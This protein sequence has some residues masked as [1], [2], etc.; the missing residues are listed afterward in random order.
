MANNKARAA[1]LTSVEAIRTKLTK[2]R[3][4]SFFAGI[5]GFDLGFERAGIS[6]A[7]HCELNSFCTSVLRRHWPSVPCVPNILEVTAAEI[8]DA[9]VWCGG[10]PCQDVSVARGWLGRDGLKGKNTGLF[11]PFAELVKQKMPTVVLMENVSGLL[12]SHDGRDFA[13]ILQTFQ[14]LGY[15]VAWRIFNTRYFGAPQ[16][17]PRVY[18]CAWKNSARSALNV[19]YEP[20]CTTTPES[21]R[22]GFLRPTRCEETGAHVPEVAFCLAATSGR[23]TGTDWS[24]SYISYHD[25]VR[26][27]TP[28]ECEKLQGFPE[29]WTLPHEDFHLSDDAIDT[30]RYHAIGNAVSVP[31][32]EWVARRIATELKATKSKA[33]GLEPVKAAIEYAKKRVPDFAS[34]KAS[35]VQIET[36][37][38]HDDAPKIKWNNG[39]VMF[40][41]LCHMSP[42]SPAPKK[43]I[44]SR[45]VDSL[46]KVKPSSRYFLSP[47]AATGILR[48]VESQERQ[49]FDPLATALTRLAMK[50]SLKHSS[51]KREP[52]AQKS[53]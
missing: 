49:L 17:R 24:R 14:L 8:P 32:V 4:N 10:F 42:V 7:F 5:G 13:V 34:A 38:D 36:F 52:L 3:L 50:A 45:V 15:G 40:G 25:E 19:L 47:N 23:H 22:L 43:P 39:G 11:Y 1:Q 44:H 21:A 2:P 9:D 27:L 26:R 28:T 29:G 20:G 48:R 37:A 31:V 51:D 6:P 53:R 30:M 46:D 18:I 41:G 33:E 35:T 16:S 12:S